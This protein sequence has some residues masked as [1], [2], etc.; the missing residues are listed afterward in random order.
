MTFA[1]GAFAQNDD[2][3]IFCT[4]LIRQLPN[5]ET[6]VIRL[7]N[8]SEIR[9]ND[10]QSGDLYQVAFVREPDSYTMVIKSLKAR[11]FNNKTPV[12]LYFRNGTKMKL[13]STNKE[14]CK[15]L[16]TVN[17]GQAQKENEI[18]EHLLEQY[19]IGIQYTAEDENLIKLKVG[20]PQ[21]EMIQELF[22]CISK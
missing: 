17:L 19:L 14:N 20:T 16:I 9:I 22:E 1:L 12:T 21:N 6:E 4:E 15:S 11:C 8:K 5:D 2:E 13:E 18:Q 7:T 10:L 3:P